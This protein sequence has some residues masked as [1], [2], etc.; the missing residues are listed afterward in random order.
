MNC[1]DQGVRWRMRSAHEPWWDAAAAAFLLAANGFALVDRDVDAPASS[2]SGF[3]HIYR[4]TLYN[5]SLRLRLSLRLGL[6]F[7]LVFVQ[8]VL[9]FEKPL[10]LLLVYDHVYIRA[11][12]N[13]I[14]KMWG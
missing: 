3:S 9:P 6:L 5:L 12:E 13:R 7:R 8:F 10:Q 2:P 14:K 4:R 1:P 11:R